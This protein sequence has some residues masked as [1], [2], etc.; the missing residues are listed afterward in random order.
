MKILPSLKI[1]GAAFLTLGIA[2][3]CASQQQQ[4]EHKPMAMMNH[5]AQDAKAAI[6]AAK[7]S[8][9]KASA[10][11]YEWRDS[12]K[13][14]KKAEAAQKAGNYDEAIKLA[15]KAKQQG[16]LAVEQ[17]Y[18][19]Q[20][21]DRSLQPAKSSAAGN[22][23]VVKGDSLWRIAAKSDI[24]NNPF[25]WPLIYKA[26]SSKIKDADLIYPGQNFDINTS[27]TDSEVSAAVHHAKTR[28]AWR[29]GAA[30]ASDKMYLASK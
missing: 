2:V 1:V 14:L 29:L 25:E 21:M 10:L 23:K 22:Y 3:G 20:K 19:E 24:Y 28:G 9:A 7:A 27:P 17:Y 4:P 18:K 30:E 13:L 26:N 6:A 16:D 8:L 5:K 12:G 15:N 11:G